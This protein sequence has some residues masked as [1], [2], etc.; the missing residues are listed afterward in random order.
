MTGAIRN[1]PDRSRY[2]D[3]LFLIGYCGLIFWL[4]SQPSLHSPDLFPQQDK[5]VHVTAYAV[6]AWLAWLAYGHW[7]TTQRF[8]ILTTVV[9]C[10]IY[11]LSDEWHQSFVPGR[12]ASLWD[13]L[14]D[15]LGALLM[16]LMMR[17]R[18]SHQPVR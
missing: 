5:L 1:M 15:T 12:D 9:F 13:W 17:L 10:M 16:S 6:M 4:S 8:L 14:A 7:L 3:V 2:F 11:G 18:S